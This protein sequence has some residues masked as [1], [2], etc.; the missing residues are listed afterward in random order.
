VRVEV[1]TDSG[2]F[3]ID[4]VAGLGRLVDDGDSG[5]TYNYSPPAKDR[6]VD[7]PTSVTVRVLERGPLRA[8]VAIDRSYSW[9]ERVLFGERAGSVETTS[10]TTVEVRAGSPLVHVTVTL[11]NP[12]RDHRLRVWFPLP[13][14]AA[15][16]E[17]ECAFAVVE[18][19]IEAEGGP[20]EFALP[21]F[22]SR[23]FVRA[24]G[25]T[26]VHEG[27]L[28]YELVDVHEGA[29]QALALTLLRC[30]GLLSNAPM[31]YRPLPAGPFIRTEGSQMIGPH[32]FRFALR[33]G[34][35][36]ADA[37]GAV[38]DAFL[39]LLVTRSA[40]QGDA[41]DA[42]TALTVTG[43]EVSAVRREAGQLEVR[44][45][46]PT[47][48]AVTVR[49]DGHRGWLVDLRGRSLEPWESSFELGPWRIATAQLTP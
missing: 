23:R 2:T 5:D 12:S 10:T 25:L 24:G 43:A 28:E 4:G 6:L 8:R 1:D 26:V 3:S 16:S 41:A 44:V 49:I 9:P 7:S 19:G 48:D 38:D 29:A 14:P 31:A 13:E 34:G 39:P 11:D 27:L 20:N 15:T 33:A 17:A 35:E 40:G 46:N 37:Y 22:P 30:T 21:T 36:V 42:G 18:R 32:E 45:F 47:P